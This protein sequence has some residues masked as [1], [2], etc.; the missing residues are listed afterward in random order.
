[1]NVRVNV[2]VLPSDSVADNFVGF[3]RRIQTMQLHSNGNI[4]QVI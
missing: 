4:T 3:R 2:R 1:M